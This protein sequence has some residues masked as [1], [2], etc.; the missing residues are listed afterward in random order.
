MVSDDHLVDVFNY[1]DAPSPFERDPLPRVFLA[2]NIP[3]GYL[4]ALPH[5]RVEGYQSRYRSLVAILAETLTLL[6]GSHIL[7]HLLF[8]NVVTAPP[9]QVPLYWLSLLLKVG[10]V[11]EYECVTTLLFHLF[12]PVRLLH[13]LVT[14]PLLDLFS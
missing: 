10:P 11:Y 2:I 12:T 6:P 7:V 1:H 3:E 4:I 8:Y 5:H 13:A 14:F 9:Y